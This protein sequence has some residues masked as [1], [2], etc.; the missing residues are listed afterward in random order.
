[1]Y[2]YNDLLILLRQYLM[3][4]DTS[5]EHCS[6]P[7]SAE[8]LYRLHQMRRLY[9]R[10]DGVSLRELSAEALQACHFAVE[11]HQALRNQLGCL[12]LCPP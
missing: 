5:S 7:G 8:M 1:M 11:A 3:L 9:R 4:L 10:R 2:I 12:S 6:G